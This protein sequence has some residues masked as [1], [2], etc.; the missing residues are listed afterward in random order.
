VAGSVEVE[1]GGRME[2][3]ISDGFCFSSDGKMKEEAMDPEPPEDVDAGGGTIAVCEEKKVVRL[4]SP[5][6][7]LR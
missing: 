4:L 1:G 6:W 2:T 5:A 3:M 7:G